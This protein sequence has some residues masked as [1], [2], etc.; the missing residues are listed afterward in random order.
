MATYSIIQ[1]MSQA[2]KQAKSAER[3]RLQSL[4]KAQPLKASMVKQ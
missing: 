2:V 1:A 4:S 3:Q